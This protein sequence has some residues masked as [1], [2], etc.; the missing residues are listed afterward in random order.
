MP[1]E[2]TRDSVLVDAETWAAELIAGPAD[3]RYH[4]PVDDDPETWKGLTRYA[5]VEVMAAYTVGLWWDLPEGVTAY[6]A[7]HEQGEGAT[8]ICPEC[9]WEMEGYETALSMAR[10]WARAAA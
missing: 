5:W 1:I 9:Y 10:Q 6:C 3:N 8:R 7:V 2:M 4:P